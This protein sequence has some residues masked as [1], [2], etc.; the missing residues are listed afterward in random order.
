MVAWIDNE[1]L[2]SQEVEAINGPCMRPVKT[3]AD[4]GEKQ[5]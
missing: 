2:L 5:A 4:V 1:K 3:R